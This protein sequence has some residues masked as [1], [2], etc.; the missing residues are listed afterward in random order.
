M[1][2][3][4][5]L[6]FDLD[7]TLIHSMPLHEHAWTVFL[8]DQGLEMDRQSFFERTSGRTNAEI[9]DFL[10]PKHSKAEHERLALRKEAIYRDLARTQL[11][12]VPGAVAFVK[13]MH[14]QGLK[15]AVCTAAPP[16]NIECAFELF[17][18]HP[19]LST[20]TCPADG[21][22]GKPHPDLY[23]EAARRM[24]IEPA[25]CLVFEDAPLGVEAGLNAGMPAVA[26]TTTVG[27]TAF[28]AHRNLVTHFA[29]FLDVNSADLLTQ[30]A[31]HKL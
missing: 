13:R 1:P 12:E 27:L 20:V 15:I 16:A 10:L 4:K 23:A 14:A 9:F 28:A 25:A 17:D 5:A 8:Q 29:N 6:L 30:A 31:A 7:G 18:L 21:L 11:K 24:N 2:T 19:M 3:I 26:L 22:R